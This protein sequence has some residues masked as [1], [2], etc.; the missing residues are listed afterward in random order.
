VPLTDVQIR[1][2]KPR[3]KP[4]KL[5]DER[6]SFLLVKPNGARLWRFK[7]AH[8]GREKLISLGDFRD[9]P[10]KRAREKRDEARR[11]VADGIDPSA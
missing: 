2:A 4:Y 5:L 8:A 9:V 6:G 1:A 10:L 7:Y 3:E 11:L